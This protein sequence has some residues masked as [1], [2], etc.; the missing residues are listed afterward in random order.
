MISRRRFLVSSTGM[1]AAAPLLLGADS[2]PAVRIGLIADTQYAD[3]DPVNT[4]YYRDSIGKLTEAITHF[5]ERELDLCVN[6]GDLIDQHWKSFDAILKPLARS[7]HKFHH[8]L[9]NHDFSVPDELKSLVPGRLG[10]KERYY[11]VV[12]A[13]FCLVMLD[14][15]DVSLYA[16]PENSPEW[17]AAKA[18]LRRLTATGA[19]NAQDWNGGVGGPQLEWFEATCRKAASTGQKVVVFSH[20]P[21]FP[22]GAHVAWNSDQLLDV[23]GCHRNVVAWLSG[24]NH[25]GALG[26]HDEVPFVTLKGM[27]ETKNT[28][29]FAEARI[30]PDHIELIGQGREVSRKLAFRAA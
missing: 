3:L 1:A 19:A 25:A 17:I 7:N 20:H 22:A 6:L 13:N 27:V 2:G 18:A 24:H 9:G 23:V 10:L 8:L 12:R 16:H 26:V 11:S 29:A 28:N 5:N 14:T 4:R 15:T 21:I 30:H